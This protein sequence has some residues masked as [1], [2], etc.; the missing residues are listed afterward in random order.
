[1]VHEAMENVEHQEVSG[2]GVFVEETCIV[3]DKR[4][5]EQV[6]EGHIQEES[7][8]VE[9]NGWSGLYNE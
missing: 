1:M 5:L 9:N 6:V 3:E 2:G 4:N 7:T 8:D